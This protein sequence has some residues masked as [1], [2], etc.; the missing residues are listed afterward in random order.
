[1]RL[2][3]IAPI[4]PVVASTVLVVSVMSHPLGRRLLPLVVFSMVIAFIWLLT[5]GWFSH[6]NDRAKAATPSFVTAAGLAAWVAHRYLMILERREVSAE[7]ER[8]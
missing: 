4:L 1:V 7:A 2:V 8:S 5:M 3:L 6:G